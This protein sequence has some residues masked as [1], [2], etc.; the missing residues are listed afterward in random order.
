[1]V[2]IFG[3][4]NFYVGEYALLEHTPF[5]P[6]VP[7][8]IL[9]WIGLDWAEEEYVPQHTSSTRSTPDFLL[10]KDHSHSP[11]PPP[12]YL[13]N[14]RSARKEY[15][16]VP[17]TQYTIV[18]SFLRRRLPRRIPRLPPCRAHLIIILSHNSHRPLLSATIP[19]SA[20]DFL[21]FLIG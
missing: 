18:C 16:C 17:Y 19:E 15:V 20:Q 5:I 3:G 6:P 11:P 9:D 12:L 14:T 13:F 4:Y 7:D 8:R 1:V 2:D 21:H 10:L